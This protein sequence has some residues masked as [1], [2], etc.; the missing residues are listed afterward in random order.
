MYSILDITLN[1]DKLRAARV[2]YTFA[3]IIR[4]LFQQND[5]Y[6]YHAFFER[7][8]IDINEPHYI[9][10]ID[11]VMCLEKVLNYFKRYDVPAWENSIFELIITNLIIDL[12]C[13][14]SDTK[15][16]GKF[17]EDYAVEANGIVYNIYTAPFK[18]FYNKLHDE[19]IERED[20]RD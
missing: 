3:D 19:Q 5:I 16:P 18:K 14:N 12:H 7:Y 11:Y 4:F 2:E 8:S 17:G 10:E 1:P 13:Y 9:S 15:L 20:K 6:L